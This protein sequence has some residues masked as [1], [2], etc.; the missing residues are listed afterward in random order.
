MIDLCFKAILKQTNAL[1]GPEGANAA[2]ETSGAVKATENISKAV[3]NNEHDIE[4]VTCGEDDL[5]VHV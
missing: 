3:S 5:S 2:I 4:V 1:S